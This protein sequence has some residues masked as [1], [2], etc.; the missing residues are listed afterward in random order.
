MTFSSSDRSQIRIAVTSVCRIVS[1]SERI[2]MR[3]WF[4]IAPRRNQPIIPRTTAAMIGQI[5]ICR[6]RKMLV[7][8]NDRTTLR[9]FALTKPDMRDR[10]AER[11]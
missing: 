5:Q 6:R 8:D 4:S 1:S 11:P 10:L 7:A 3:N 2:S 9:A